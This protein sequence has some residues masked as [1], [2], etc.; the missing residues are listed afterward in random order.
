[1]GYIDIIKPSIQL[2]PYIR[3]YWILETLG[4]EMGMQRITPT[5]CMQLIFH[6]QERMQSSLH[7]DLQPQSFISGQ[8]IGY[9]DLEATGKV[10]MIVVVF[11]PYGAKA[12]FPM[13]MD[14]FHENNVSINDIDDNYLKD[15]ESKIL[16]APNNQTCINLIEQYFTKKLYAFNEYNFKRIRSTL[17]VIN[18]QSNVTVS[19]LS[20]VS[21]LSQKQFNRIF[22][23]YVG[24]NPKEFLR[25]IRF[26]RA[27]YLLQL[28]PKML[29]TQLAF[30]CG[31]YD[32]PHLVKEFKS[33]SGYT[34]GEY[35]AI[36]PPHSDY[37]SEP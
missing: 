17:S 11:Q 1:M 32:Q 37:F 31:Y 7:E 20:D 14:E 34:P 16:E 33:M 24:S 36:C 3:Y 10:N 13:P 25:I 28:N 4:N 12:F 30:E 15:L 21:C 6:R 2:V 26:Q 18:S 19:T 8:T 23:E 35:L 22:S 9:S 5:G 27:L 29:L